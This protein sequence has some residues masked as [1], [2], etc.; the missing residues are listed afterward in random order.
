MR[1][2]SSI[3]A[4]LSGVVRTW[5]SRTG[6]RSQVAE[7]TG[8]SPMRPEAA[9]LH[10]PD[11]YRQPAGD[12]GMR[13]LVVVLQPDEFAVLVGQVLQRLPDLP[14]VVDLLDGRRQGHQRR[15][16]RVVLVRVTM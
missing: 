7:Q 6:V 3:T 8:E 2:S 14:H 15:I 1:S 12:L 13:E 9:R 4:H 10:R 16:G 11:R 5:R